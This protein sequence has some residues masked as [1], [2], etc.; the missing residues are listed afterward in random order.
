MPTPQ[1]ALGHEFVMGGSLA[2]VV[3]LGWTEKRN[4]DRV[5]LCAFVA[6]ADF[7]LACEKM[8]YD[9][10]AGFPTPAD[11]ADDLASDAEA[12]MEWRFEVETGATTLDFEAWKL[13]DTVTVTVTLDPA[14]FGLPSNPDTPGPSFS[15][16]VDEDPGDPELCHLAY[17]ICNS[18]PGELRRRARAASRR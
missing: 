18:Y 4:G 2:T 12:H 15:F 14:A 17:A 11:L 13:A 10:V 1:L 9:R 16:D 3:G 7:G 8:R 6:S 5:P